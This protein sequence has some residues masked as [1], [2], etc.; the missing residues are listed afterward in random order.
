MDFN[1]PDNGNNNSDNDNNNNNNDYNE[2]NENNE[3]ND[4]NNLDDNNDNN[5]ENESNYAFL[6]PEHPF[7]KRYQ[8]SLEEQLKADELKLRLLYKEKNNDAKILKKEREEIGISLY[9]LQQKFALIENSFNDEYTKCKILEEQQKIETDKLTEEIKSYNNKFQNVKEQEKLVLQSNEDLNQ[10]NSMIQ[11]DLNQ[12][13]S[14]IQYVEKYNLQVESDIKVT[15]NATHKTENLIINK[16][17]QKKE[18]DFFIDVLEMRMKNLTEKK[19]L[20]QAQ[21]ESQEKETKEAKANLAE[22]DEEIKLL[23]LKIL[24]NKKMKK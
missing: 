10:I 7:L 3:F 19:M 20:F 17:R 4:Y 22:A 6:P 24:K 8:I 13:N 14:M 23:L 16:E 12:I 5:E 1:D 9:N 15:K 18:Q 2:N 21:I 11:E